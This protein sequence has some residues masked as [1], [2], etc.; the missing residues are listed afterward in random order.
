MTRV[1]AISDE[2]RETLYGRRL[3]ELEPDLVVSCGDLP[4]DYLEYI[5]TVTN[6]PLLWVPGNHDAA[7]HSDPLRATMLLPVLEG[8]RSTTYGP[9]GAINIDGCIVDVKGLRVAGLGGSIRY[10]GGPHQYTDEQMSRRANRLARRAR[11]ARLRDGRL[12]D[13]LVTH[14]PARG[15]GDDDDPAHRGFSS[16]GRLVQ[17][18]SPRVMVHGH[19]HPHSRR[20]RDHLIGKTTVLNVVGYRMVEVGLG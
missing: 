13:L 20:V 1:L 9:P 4:F 10:C 6:V 15:V 2:I 3:L 7:P 16:F 19:V 12:V 14:A 8:D 17:A 5:V 11:V 18:L